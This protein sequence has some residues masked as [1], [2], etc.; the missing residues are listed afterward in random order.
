MLQ[1]SCF[2]QKNVC[3]WCGVLCDATTHIQRP[4]CWLCKYLN[5]WGNETV[6]VQGCFILKNNVIRKFCRPF[7]RD[8][9][10]PISTHHLILV[11]IID[12]GRDEIYFCPVFLIR[13]S[14]PKSRL[15]CLVEWILDKFRMRCLFCTFLFLI[16]NSA[17]FITSVFQTLRLDLCAQEN[18]ERASG[19]SSAFALSLFWQ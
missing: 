16:S 19:I 17:S 6:F 18:V 9:V 14:I 2:C 11:P 7:P 5:Q 13:G 4:P 15:V 10:D 3:Q 8:Y 12:R 1:H